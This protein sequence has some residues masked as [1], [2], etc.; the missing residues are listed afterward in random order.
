VAFSFRYLQNSVTDP[1]CSF[2]ISHPKNQ[3]QYKVRLEGRFEANPGFRFKTRV[4]CDLAPVKTQALN[5]GWLLFQDTEYSL[6]RINLKFWLRAC[7]FDVPEYGNRIYAYENDVLYDFTSFMHYGK[8]IRGILMLRWAPFDWL[9]LWLRF[10]TVY[11]TSRQIGTGWDEVEG[12]RQ[13]EIEIQ[14]RIKI[15]G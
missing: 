10:S 1:E 5:P 8:G 13:N 3:S 2:L 6:S 15:P 14:V 11:Y 4:E 9:D 7:F 12:N